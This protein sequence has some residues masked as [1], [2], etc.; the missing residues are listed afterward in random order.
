[1]NDHLIAVMDLAFCR[2]QFP[3]YLRPLRAENLSAKQRIRKFFLELRD[4]SKDQRSIFPFRRWPDKNLIPIFD[5]FIEI[6]FFSIQADFRGFA[7]P[8]LRLPSLP[9]DR[10]R[11]SCPA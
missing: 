7:R 9:I 5:P 4:P 2:T 11:K 1:M 6:R 8:S 10:I 3:V